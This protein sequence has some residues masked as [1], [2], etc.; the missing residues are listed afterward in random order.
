MVSKKLSENCSPPEAKV[1]RRKSANARERKRMRSLNQALDSL[2]IA[3][4]KIFNWP[5]NGKQLKHMLKLSKIE[6]LRI[7]RNYISA[8]TQILETDNKLEPTMFARILCQ[9]LS[10]ATVNIIT[11]GQGDQKGD[12][13]DDVFSAC[14]EDCGQ[15][16]VIN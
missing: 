4:S 6:T 2:R 13:C 14:F 7:A 15:V 1:S 11:D 10:Q 3:V 9:G 5:A 16:R 12:P 8:L